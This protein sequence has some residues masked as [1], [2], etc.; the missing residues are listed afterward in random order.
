M[1]GENN[2]TPYLQMDDLGGPNPPFKETP[3][4]GKFPAFS[5]LLAPKLRFVKNS[6]K[7]LDSIR[8]QIAKSI[9][10]SRGPGFEFDDEATAIF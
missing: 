3:K 6:V 8:F 2:G 7:P 10:N 4:S 9:R 1:D 5:T